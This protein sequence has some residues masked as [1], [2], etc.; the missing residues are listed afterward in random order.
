MRRRQNFRACLQRRVFEAWP[1]FLTGATALFPHELQRASRPRVSGR[2]GPASSL[3]RPRVDCD[4]AL[5]EPRA[6]HESAR[7]RRLS[8]RGAQKSGL[9]RTRAMALRRVRRAVRLDSGAAHAIEDRPRTDLVSCQ[10]GGCEILLG[11]AIDS[12]RTIGPLHKRPHC[13]GI[14]GTRDDLP[15]VHMVG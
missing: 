13:T 4:W 8:P 1:L 2:G 11:D 10:R 5:S 9:L 15:I 3:Y 7:A 12:G 14:T 6:E